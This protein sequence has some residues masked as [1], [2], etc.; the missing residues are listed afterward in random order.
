MS[1]I[2]ALHT[3][4]MC[5]MHPHVTQEQAH[6]AAVRCAERCPA[7]TVLWV[8]EHGGNIVGFVRGA[9]GAIDALYVTRGYRTRGVAKK[10]MEVTL[11]TRGSAQGTT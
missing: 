2:L 10:L 9:R 8:A 6:L 11:A 7:S 3:D 4:K 5:E 1:D